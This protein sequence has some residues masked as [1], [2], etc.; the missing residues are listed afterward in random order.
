MKMNLEDLDSLSNSINFTNM[1]NL[2]KFLNIISQFDSYESFYK[3]MIIFKSIPTIK[4][5]DDLAK[6]SSNLYLFEFLKSQGYFKLLEPTQ[7]YHLFTTACS[8]DSIDIAMLIFNY[9]D[10]DL[11]GV[12]EFMLNY[13]VQVG[14]N[15]EYIIFRKI[16]E[17]NI[18]HFNPEEIEEIFF[19]IL[20]NSNLEFVEWFC[21]LNLIDLKNKRIKQKI[22]NKILE[23]V[24]TTLDF[25]VAKFIS[26]L[27]LKL[28][29]NENCN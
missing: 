22:G 14:T 18:I 3:F 4:Q 16:W 7:K 12:K 23:N 26:S 9:T 21:S 5:V 24:E 29:K 13:L 8:H 11:E 1:D 25:Q 20:K 17:K 2:K 15:T 19:F 28:Y 27:Y 6:S 10:I